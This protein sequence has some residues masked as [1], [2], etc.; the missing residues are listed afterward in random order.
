MRKFRKSPLVRLDQSFNKCFEITDSSVSR[1]PIIPSLQ[2]P[3]VRDQVPQAARL[4]QQ[5]IQ[6]NRGILSSFGV[7][8]DFQYDGNSLDLVFRAGTKIGALPLLSPT[9]GKPDYGLIIK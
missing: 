7:T 2:M 3:T 1:I 4:G 6:Q 9:S 5:F 8:A